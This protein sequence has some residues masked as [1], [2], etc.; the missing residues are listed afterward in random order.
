MEAYCVKC[1]QKREITQ[2]EPTFT[3]TGTPATRGVCGVCGTG[4]YRMGKT[5]AHEG[6]TPPEVSETKMRR[7][8]RRKKR[9]GKLVI[10]ESPA[11]ARTIS[12]FLDKEFKV[13]ASIGHVRDLLR[14]QISVD[15]EN[16]FQP[17]YRVPNEKREIVKELKS[18]A[19]ETTQVYL[20]TDHDREGEAIAW[21]LLE[22]A[23]ID[24][25]IAK[26]VVFNEITKPAIQH[27]F[28]EPRDIAMDLV[29]AQQARRILDRLVGYNLS[30]LLWE[31]V[32][33]R[34]SAGRV[35]SVALRLI[36]ERE[37]EI[38]DF[39]PQEYWTIDAE[40]L[41]EEKPPAFM[42]RLVK[43]NGEKPELKSNEEVESLV[44]DL[45]SAD[46]QISGVRRGQR[47][48]KP[49]AP[50][51]TSTMQQTA[52][53]R[54]SYT[55]RR[56]MVIAQQL[57]EGIDFGEG[58]RVGLITYMRTDST[59]V[60][61][62]AQMEARKLITDQYGETYLPEQPPIYRTR[63]RL[64]QEAHEAIRPTSVM[65]TP[66]SLKPYLSANQY[67]LYNLI[68]QRFVASQMKP[69]IYDTLTIEVTG[70]SVNDEY[71][72]RV[73]ASSL[74]FDG[75]LSVYKADRNGEEERANVK[76]GLDQ[77]LKA[78]LTQ[79]PDL[80]KGDFVLLRDI[81][82]DQHFTQ[83]PPRFSDASL[84]RALEENGIGRPSTY[85][86]IISTLRQRGYIERQN[87][88][89]ITTEIGEIVNDL[90][91]AHFPNIVDPGFTAR[92]E[93]QLD[94][95]AG[96]KRD[97]VAVIRD[98]YEPFAEQ[99]KIAEDAM[100]EMKAEPEE[101][102]RECPECGSP[103]V[104]RH[105]RY[106]KF[107]GCSNFPECRH[108][109]PWLEKI[110]VKCPKCGG[111]LVARRTRKGRPFYGCENYPECEFTSWKR[112][113]ASPC[114]SCGGLLIVENRQK[115]RCT[116]CDEQFAQSILQNE[117]SDPV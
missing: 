99:L 22:A 83:P 117:E 15:V 105:G 71:L 25:D 68:W 27:A 20:A 77:E 72:F 23:E 1:K 39:V 49:S 5:A 79:L 29:D 28:E 55:A 89:L 80:Q 34:L 100:P 64:A 66:K 107:I 42:A 17:K 4:L 69:A 43:H 65:R 54:F 60:S 62:Q 11:K 67:K 45:R 38:A 90:I 10:V 85:A 35:Q 97:W 70:Q 3:A 26:R 95:I 24:R 32:R 12:R 18:A 75:F 88:R 84:V 76:G 58:E 16:D 103:L 59:Q 44:S 8:K 74:R 19:A 101:I 2:A 114:P 30:P 9:S 51:T 115:A 37:R 13:M 98:F 56:T 94:E 116:E 78:Q 111:D 46:Y 31:K 41:N 82:T 113:L 53:Q 96:G 7:K 108:T 102:G 112:P 61:K 52:S 86:P 110:G 92:M 14:S 63:G 104:L 81:N 91:V 87:R 109:E 21:H 57:Y 50:F 6:L 106:G 36:V 40:F 48:R 73:T 33:G 93:E 47:T